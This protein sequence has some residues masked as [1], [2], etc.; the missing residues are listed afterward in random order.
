MKLNNLPL[1][2]V[3]LTY[4]ELWL[5]II[6]GKLKNRFEA[7]RQYHVPGCSEL[8]RCPRNQVRF[9]T[10]NSKKHEMAKASVCYDIQKAGQQFI[11]EACR[12]DNGDVIDIVNL[13]EMEEWEIVHTHGLEKTV[14]NGR[15]VVK[16]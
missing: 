9:N 2:A 5:M 11:T 15:I 6:M 4:T 8:V 3:N 13:D 7:H 10:H 14:S 12:K 16:V 1:G